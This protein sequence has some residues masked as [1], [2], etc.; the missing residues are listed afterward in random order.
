MSRS[1]PRK[2]GQGTSKSGSRKKGSKKVLADIPQDSLLGIKLVNWDSNPCT[3]GKDKVKIIWYF[4]V[5][6]VK[7][8]NKIRSCLFA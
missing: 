4:L 2:M 8:G 1:G 6:W 5:E 3:K 7:K